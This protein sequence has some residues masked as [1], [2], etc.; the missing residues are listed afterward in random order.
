[1]PLKIFL[2]SL[3]TPTRMRKMTLGANIVARAL[4]NLKIQE[5]LVVQNV[6]TPLE[7]KLSL[8]SMP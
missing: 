4:E 6:T 3:P 1:M 2:N 7:M 8:I 5:S